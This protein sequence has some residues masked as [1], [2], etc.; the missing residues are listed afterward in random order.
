[1]KQI[2]ILRWMQR[3]WCCAWEAFISYFAHFL[4]VQLHFYRLRPYH[5][6]MGGRI[7]HK[8]A[9]TCDKCSRESSS[10]RPFG[11]EQYA[12]RTCNI[13]VWGWG[14]VFWRKY[15][16]YVLQEASFMCLSIVALGRSKLFRGR[17][18]ADPETRVN[19]VRDQ[20]VHTVHTQTV[21]TPRTLHSRPPNLGSEVWSRAAQFSTPHPELPLWKTSKPTWMSLSEEL[22]QI[23]AHFFWGGGERV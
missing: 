3:F 8:Q 16:F 5:T 20:S 4:L 22:H 19:Q 18:E 7:K 9:V 14:H 2:R 21:S 15:M 23:G 6:A 10:V 11:G 17:C 13:C 1:M 12:S